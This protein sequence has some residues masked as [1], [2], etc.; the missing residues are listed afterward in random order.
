MLPK[1]VSRLRAYK[2]PATWRSFLV[3]A[4]FAELGVVLSAA[5]HGSAHLLWALLAGA[6]IAADVQLGFALRRA[7]RPRSRSN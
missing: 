2:L 1:T 7:G 5:T 6:C 4:A 3:L